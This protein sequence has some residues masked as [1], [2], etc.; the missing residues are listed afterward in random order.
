MLRYKTLNDKTLEADSLRGIAE[1][2]WSLMLVR[3]PTLEEWMIGSAKRAKMWNGSVIR[4]SSPEEHVRD[5]VEAGLLTPL[6]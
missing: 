2:L 6:E 3:E 5:L 1:A 4:T